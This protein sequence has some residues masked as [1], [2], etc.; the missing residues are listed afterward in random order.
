M[1]EIP[2]PEQQ[3][4]LEKQ[5]ATN[6]ALLKVEKERLATAKESGATITERLDLQASIEKRER[7]QLEL[8]I[9]LGRLSGEWLEAAQKRLTL[10][11]ESEKQLKKQSKTLDSIGKKSKFVGEA[12]KDSFIGS[13]ID[14]GVSIDQVGEKLKETF[15]PANITGS[16]FLAI[17]QATIATVATAGQLRGEVIGM[18]G[19]I[20]AFDN[21]VMGASSGAM[22]FGVGVEQASKASNA[23]FQSMSSFSQASGTLKNDLI[24]TAASFENLGISASTFGANMQIAEKSFGMTGREALNLQKGMVRFSAGIGVSSGKLA[25]DFSAN[26]QSFVAYGDAG[27]EMF[28]DLARQSKQTGIA[29]NDLLGITSQFDTFEGAADAAGKLNAVLGGGVIDSM[30][31][32]GATEAERIEILQNSV[33]AS[34]KS[35]DSMSR[36]EKMAV[37]NAAGISDM[38]KATALFSEKA[39]QNAKDVNGTAIS[40]EKLEEIQRKSVATGQDLKLIFQSFAVA[41]GPIVSIIKFF[42]NGF[43][44]LNDALGGNLTYLIM[45]GILIKKWTSFAA[46]AAKTQKAWLAIKGFA[47]LLRKKEFAE[48]TALALKNYSLATSQGVVNTTAAASRFSLLGMGKALGAFGT[49]AAPAIPILL[50]LGATFL[51]IGIGVG[52]AAAGISLLVDSFVLLLGLLIDNIAV[53]PQVLLTLAG[54]SLAF[55]ALGAGMII[56]GAGFVVFALGLAAAI[57]ILASLAFAAPIAAYVIGT[58]AASALLLG[59]AMQL[60]SVGVESIVTALSSITAEGGI[61]EFLTQI[62]EKMPEL[63]VSVLSLSTA[64]IALGASMIVAGVGFAIFAAGLASGIATLAMMGPASLIAAFVIGVITASVMALGLSFTLVSNGITSTVSALNSITADGGMIGFVREIKEQLPELLTSVFS[65]ST[66]IITLG[67][68]M[69]IAALGFATFAFGLASGIGTLAMMGPASLVAAFVIGV[70]T[71]SVTALGLSFML[72]SDSIV[73]MVSALNSVP[74]EGGII[75]FTKQVG[76]VTTENVDNLSSLMDQAER[77]VEVQTSLKVGALVDPFVEALKQ[78]TSVVAPAASAATGAGSGKQE[79]VLVLDDREF[80]RAVTGVI[81]DKMK[82]S[83]A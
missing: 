12:W 38:T 23:L 81:D 75:E 15:S 36:F 50:T 62:T 1:A 21:T 10:L 37:A 74:T 5:L 53:M 44:R 83:M 35:F 14:S 28:K 31:L 61:A 52:I 18:Q 65:L 17:Q 72:V 2:T 8:N 47:S 59:F 42:T 70:I 7:T 71:T 60:A 29:M 54:L 20:E 69:G 9:Q 43:L 80:G 25:E 40:Q 66:A 22:A 13:L 45:A 46:L 26:A 30:Q 24:Q 58:I 33:S 78:M 57:V 39:R 6:E 41:V 55:I 4:L 16:F 34:G 64:V 51:M 67:T 19:D 63:L 73:S 48:K 79:I 76:E 77:Y 11:E 68:A 56:A 3:E 32:L 49:A 27:I 82:I